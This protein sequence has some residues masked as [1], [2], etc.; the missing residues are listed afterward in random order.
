MWTEAELA[1]EPAVVRWIVARIAAAPDIYVRQANGAVTAGTLL[2]ADLG[3]DS[4]GRISLF[5]EIG[6]ALG[7]EIEEAEERGV[8]GW[9]SVGDV[10]AFVRR[11]AGRSR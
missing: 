8:S 1:D 2:E 5:Y 7:V 6:D 9:R 4:I 10:V 11:S 3:I